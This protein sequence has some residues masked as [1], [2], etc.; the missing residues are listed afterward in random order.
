MVLCFI[1]DY[2]RDSHEESFRE[3]EKSGLTL[4]QEFL[5]DFVVEENYEVLS[6]DQISDGYTVTVYC[7]SE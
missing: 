1:S 4:M 7:L 2:V 3:G 5:T 6:S